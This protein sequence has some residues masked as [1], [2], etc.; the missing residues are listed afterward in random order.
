MSWGEERCREL[1]S[2]GRNN[3]DGVRD[4][5]NTTKCRIGVLVESRVQVGQRNALAGA[6][7]GNELNRL[8]DESRELFDVGHIK[9]C[10]MRGDWRNGLL[11]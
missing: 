3:V 5:R 7:L 4:S 6:S 11:R 8:R 2:S 10:L 9:R 1:S